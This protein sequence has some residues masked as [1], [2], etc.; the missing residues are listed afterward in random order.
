MS[1]PN[2]ANAQSLTPRQIREL[3]FYEEYSRK[4]APGAIDLDPIRGLEE[5]PWNPAWF[6]YQITR[7]LYRSGARTL[8]ELGCGAGI[9]TVRFAA[10]GYE[11][12]AVDLAPACIELTQSHARLNGFESRI[13]LAVG[14]TE[15]LT[16]PDESFDV[17]AGLD[18]LHHVEIAQTMAEVL[19]VLKPGET[20]VFK[21]WVEVPFLDRLRRSPLVRWLAPL[22]RS[23][24]REVTED[25]QKL[26]ARDV[27]LIRA[28]CPDM[29][30]YRFRILARLNRWVAARE[31][32]PSRLERWDAR[33]LRVVPPLARLGGAA[34]FV[35]RKPDRSRQ[36]DPGGS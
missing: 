21:E 1:S 9:A 3:A 30:V 15:Q 6:T 36:T 14:V 11:V 23:I 18:V 8:L 5:R 10:V 35:L 29:S 17:V 27:R 20:A 31:H 16:F 28:A 26:S 32:A 4:L 22:G 7:D 25:E 2:A 33:L 19:R 13:R 34:V 12:S 24:E